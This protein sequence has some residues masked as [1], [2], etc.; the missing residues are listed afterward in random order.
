MGPWT[1]GEEMKGTFS[2]GQYFSSHIIPSGLQNICIKNSEP[3]LTTHV[4]PKDQGIIWCFKAHYQARFIQ[5]A[6]DQYDKGVTPTKI[7][8]IN[9][10]EA[11]QLADTAWQEVDTT[12]IQNCWQKAG[13]LPD[14]ANAPPVNPSVSI[15][16]L[17]HNP[18]AQLGPIAQ[19]EK[20]VEDALDGLV[21]MRALQAA[22][23]M[24]I[25]W[26]LNLV[27]KSH[28]MT[29]VSDKEIYQTIMDTIEAH[30]NIKFN[31][32]DDVDI[33]GPPEPLS[34]CCNI[35]KAV[36]INNKYIGG[37]DDPFSHE[38]EMILASFNRQIHLDKARNL[39]EMFMTDYFTDV[40][41]N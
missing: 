25:E 9:Q 8:E 20:Q 26:L 32:N 2:A 21:Q 11:M 31:G 15:S 27:G 1:S 18:L 28:V 3:N 36:S 37:L 29:E 13:I 24:D 39:K 10:L 14:I 23:R 40:S 33:D 30:D 7:Y 35:L 6:I 17:L 38:M 19:A 34:N 4:Q 5:Q 16:A 12:T 22:N 41:S